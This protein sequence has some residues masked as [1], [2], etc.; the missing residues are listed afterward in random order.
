VYHPLASHAYPD[1]PEFDRLVLGDT[2]WWNVGGVTRYVPTLG[3]TSYG[4][5][6][7]AAPVPRH[8][9]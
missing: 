6:M 9:L 7:G 8:D 3:R 2:V 1:S 5:I 4:R